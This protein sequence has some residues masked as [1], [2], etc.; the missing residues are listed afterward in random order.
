[1]NCVEATPMAT[2]RTTHDAV[3]T[4]L[5]LVPIEPLTD[6]MCPAAKEAAIRRAIRALDRIVR[7]D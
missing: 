2:T 5:S 1:M 3:L 7:A 6:D 4:L